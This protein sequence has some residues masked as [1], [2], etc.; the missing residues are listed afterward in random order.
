MAALALVPGKDIRTVAALSLARA[1]DAAEA[2]RL[3]DSLNRDFPQ[4]TLMQ[5]DWLPAILAAIELNATNPAEAMEF[6]K[7]AAPYELGLCEPFQ[8]GMMYP[9]YLR[10]QAYLLARQGKEAGGGVP[11]DH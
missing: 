9:V 11:E 7:T 2:K 10:G 5:G 8:L 3:A 4:D 1:G 6:L